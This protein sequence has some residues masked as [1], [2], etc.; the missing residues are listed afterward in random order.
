MFVEPV[1]PPVL[2]PVDPT[3]T[4][5]AAAKRARAA[6]AWLD[7]GLDLAKRPGAVDPA[8]GMIDALTNATEAIH[9]A[10]VA[11]GELHEVRDQLHLALDEATDGIT[12]LREQGGQAR[13]HAARRVNLA[14]G[15]IDH[16]IATLVEVHD[17]APAVDDPVR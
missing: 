13:D 11:C 9:E 7:L 4:A 5:G 17:P 10:I 6:R 15:L 8:A 12:A 3:F 16:A 14:G 2:G 1:T